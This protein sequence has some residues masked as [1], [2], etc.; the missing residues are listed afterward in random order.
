VKDFPAIENN[1]F[2]QKSAYVG[3]PN[4]TIQNLNNKAIFIIKEKFKPGSHG[5]LLEK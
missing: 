3:K 1:S 4:S 5:S 2:D